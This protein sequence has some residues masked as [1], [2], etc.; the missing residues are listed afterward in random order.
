MGFILEKSN[1]LSL[2]GEALVPQS[3]TSSSGVSFSFLLR[4]KYNGTSSSASVAVAG[5]LCLAFTPSPL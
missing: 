1:Y 2:Y 4:L 3:E 5:K